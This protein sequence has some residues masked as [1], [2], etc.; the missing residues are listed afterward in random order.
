M[1][2]VTRRDAKNPT[3]L[4]IIRAWA[5]HGSTEPVRAHIR[6]SRNVSHGFERSF[7][8]SRTDSVVAVVEAWLATVFDNSVPKRRCVTE[9]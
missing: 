9:Q 1:E 6:V 8:V 7:T 3:G 5:E 4:M 2:D